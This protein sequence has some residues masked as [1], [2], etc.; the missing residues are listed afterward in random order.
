MSKCLFVIKK[1][2]KE[3]K[4]KDFFMLLLVTHVKKLKKF[5]KFYAAK[6]IEVIYIL[7]KLFS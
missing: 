1:T 4:T 6:K 3:Q 5:S 7:K 2:I